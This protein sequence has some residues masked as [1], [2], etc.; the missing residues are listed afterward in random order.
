MS[1]SNGLTIR[2]ALADCAAALDAAGIDTARLDA[3]LLLA[4][5][6]QVGRTHLLAHPEVSAEDMTMHT[7]S[8]LRP[9]AEQIPA[10]EGALHLD[11]EE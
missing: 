7:L 5:C 1:E 4:H 8:L 3:E 10:D 2:A 6:L 11:R 9:I